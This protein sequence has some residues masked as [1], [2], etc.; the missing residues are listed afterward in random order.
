MENYKKLQIQYKESQEEISNLKK[1]IPES[2]SN[3]GL[4]GRFLKRKPTDD[5]DKSDDD[6]I[7]D[8]TKK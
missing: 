7:N 4:F 3:N 6:T 8:E 2:K 5:Q 1:L